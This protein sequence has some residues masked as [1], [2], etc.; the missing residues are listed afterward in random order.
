MAEGPR[1]VVF[2]APKDPD[3][4]AHMPGLDFKP[5]LTLPAETFSAANVTVTI[6]DRKF[7]TD[8]TAT[9]L[10]SGSVGVSNNVVAF[11]VQAGSDNHDYEADVKVTTLPPYSRIEHG[12]VII[13][14][15]LR[16]R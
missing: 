4:I 12:D 11:R 7:R 16:A 15:R 8:H 14:V 13:P 3:D 6:I 1:P 5:R 10:V 2:M 9:M